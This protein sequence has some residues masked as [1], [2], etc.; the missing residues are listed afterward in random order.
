MKL[1]GLPADW[2]EDN[3]IVFDATLPHDLCQLANQQLAFSESERNQL[4][5]THDRVRI[6][7]LEPTDGGSSCIVTF[8]LRSTEPSRAGKNAAGLFEPPPPTAELS[9]LMAASQ[10]EESG[11][12]TLSMLSDE[13]GSTV[14]G[15]IRQVDAH[16]PARAPGGD[17]RR[18]S[19]DIIVPAPVPGGEG[20]EGEGGLAQSNQGEGG[21]RISCCHSSCFTRFSIF[22]DSFS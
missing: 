1:L 10:H 12:M 21:S 17:R 5:L 6:D 15:R 2:A 9:A 14:M 22:L 16:S 18:K 11:S 4:L 19:W 20:G 7:S 13:Y 3:R 8:A